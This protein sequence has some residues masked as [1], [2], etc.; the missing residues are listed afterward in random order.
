MSKFSTAYSTAPAAAAK[1]GL[2]ARIL[3][4]L[5]AAREAQAEREV[6]RY[7]SMRPDHVLR[8]IGMTEEEIADLRRRH[9]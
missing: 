1:S 3:S 4:S 5:A 6:S 2:W 8:D 9:S 7:L